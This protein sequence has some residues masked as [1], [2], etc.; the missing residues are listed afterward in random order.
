VKRYL[1][2]EKWAE[3]PIAVRP[4]IM[5]PM[6]ATPPDGVSDSGVIRLEEKDRKNE[7]LNNRLTASKKAK[8]R[9]VPDLAEAAVTEATAQANSCRIAVGIIVNR[10][11]TA[12]AIYEKLREANGDK[13]DVVVEL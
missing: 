4:M 11:A 7:G 2:S 8:L 10:V 1:D 6:T 12:K 5:V 9:A 13:P 3:K